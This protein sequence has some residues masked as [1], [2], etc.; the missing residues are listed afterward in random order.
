MDETVRRSGEAVRKKKRALE[1]LVLT[2]VGGVAP[3]L[4][5]GI[6]RIATIEGRQQK[7]SRERDT[8]YRQVTRIEGA[9]QGVPSYGVNGVLKGLRGDINEMIKY[10]AEAMATPGNRQ[11]GT[12]G[13]ETDTEEEPEGRKGK[14]VATGCRD[15][16]IT[17]G[18]GDEKQ[19]PGSHRHPTRRDSLHSG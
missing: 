3:K 7:P 15:R 12:T 18:G 8:N 11:G 17:P 16:Q 10:M 13:D 6:H 1:C 4:D 2:L 14:G 5:K 9:I 19:R